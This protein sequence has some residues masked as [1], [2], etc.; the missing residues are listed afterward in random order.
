VKRG[1]LKFSFLDRYV[2]LCELTSS[3]SVALN[4]RVRGSTTADKL[5]R[6]TYIA[7]F[8]VLGGGARPGRPARRHLHRDFT[9]D[10]RAGRLWPAR[11][12][13]LVSCFRGNDIIESCSAGHS[14]A[15]RVFIQGLPRSHNK[16]SGTKFLPRVR[17]DLS[18][19]HQTDDSPPAT[20]GRPC[21]IPKIIAPAPA[22]ET[23]RNNNSPI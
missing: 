3:Y 20:F 8:F 2:R 19:T 6:P 12:S 10:L 23:I 18:Q 5:P 16:Q 14:Y 13:I 7:V 9:L 21:L 22:I 11:K 1:N 17:D 4:W 15:P